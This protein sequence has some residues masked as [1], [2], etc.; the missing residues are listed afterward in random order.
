MRKSLSPV[1]VL[2]RCLLAA[3]LG[4]F[5]VSNQL[6]AQCGL[7]SFPGPGTPYTPTSSF[8]NTQPLGGGTYDEFNVVAG[9]IYSFDF[10]GLTAPVTGNYWD[11]TIST[12]SAIIQYNNSISPIQN[13]WTNGIGCPLTPAPYTSSTEWYAN[14][15]GTVRVNVSTW[16]AINGC[17]LWVSGEGSAVLS[18]KEC[19]TTPDPG[20]G[21]NNWNVD[22]FATTDI[23]LPS[24]IIGARY[25]TYVDNASGTNFITTNYWAQA[26]NP[27]TAPGWTGCQMPNNNFVL[28]ARREGF[29]CGAY[30]VVVNQAVNSIL[31]FLNGTQIY[32]GANINSGVTVG[33]YALTNTDLLEI[34]TNDICNASGGV[35]NVSV[36]PIAP[37]TVHGG[38]IGGVVN[39]ANVCAG[40]PLG[41]FTNITSGSGGTA[42]YTNSAPISYKW[43]LSTNGGASFT[44]VPGVNTDFWN[45]G[46]T[47]PSGATYVVKRI[48][49]DECGNQSPSNTITIFGVPLPNGSISPVSQTICPG[50]T[51]TLTF[52]FNPGTPPFN[53]I[54]TN[55][56]AGGNFPLN[57]LTNGATAQV[58]PSSNANYSFTSITDA[59]GCVTTTGFTQN[60]AVI[61]TPPIVINNIIP[62]PSLCNGSSSGSIV[63]NATGGQ[64]PLS[65][66][67]DGGN[68]FQPGNTFNNLAVGNYN[69]VVKDNLGCSQAGGSVTIGQ[70]SAITMSLTK[71]D[72]SCA[73]VFDG[74]ITVTASGGVPPY[75]YALNGG[76]VQ[77]SN[78]ITGLQTG[79]YVVDVYDSHNCLDTQSIT[80]NPSYVVTLDTLATSDISCNGQG[81]GTI[82]VQ[83]TG[84]IPTYQ[85]SINGFTFQN[86][87]TFTGL[88]SSNYIVIGRDSKGCTASFNVDITQPAP[89]IIAIDSIANVTC[90]NSGNGGIYTSVSGGTPGYTY[91]W[92]NAGVNTP[93]DLNISGG[94]YNVTVTDA[95]NCTATNGATV[96][97]PAAL[98]LNIALHNN[99]F[100]NN[101]SS[102]AILLTA[103]GG[104]APYA[105]AWS[106]GATTQDLDSLGAG[107]YVATVTDINGC[108]NTISQTLTNPT[109]LVASV[110][111]TNVT[112]AGANDGTAGVT[113]SGGNPPYTYLWSNFNVTSSITS[114]S[115]GEYV[116]I[117]SDHSGCQ[118]RDS[119]NVSEPTPIIFTTNVTNISCFN[120]ND[121]SVTTSVTGGTQPYSYAWSNG[122]TT[123]N[124]SSL[125]GGPITGTVTDANHCSASV[126]LNI[127]NPL[128]IAP[129]F[130][131][132]NVTCF[133]D[134]T[135]AIHTTVSGGTPGYT[136]SWTGGATTADLSNLTP[137]TYYVTITDSRSCTTSDSAVVTSPGALYTSGILKNVSC[138]GLCD[139]YIF[140]TPYGGTLPYTYRWSNGYSTENVDLLCGGSY[141]LTLTDA[142][143]CQVASLYIIHEPAQL[144]ETI[145]TTN[146]SCFGNCNGS[147]ASVP[148]GGTTPYQYLWSNF[149]TDSMQSSLCAGKYTL[150]LTDSNGCHLN[151]TV[152]LTQPS[153]IVIAGSV[154]NVACSGFNTGAISLNISG[155]VSPFTFAWSNGATTQNLTGLTAGTDTVVVTDAHGCSETAIFVVA[156]REVIHTT[157]SLY[158]PRCAGGN[159]GFISVVVTGGVI[160]YTYA[161]STTPTQVGA[162]ATNL[163][164]GT[165]ILT[166]TDSVSCS[167]TISA[168]LDNPAPI[169]VT[170][171]N[172]NSRCYNNPNGTVIALASGGFPPYNYTLNGVFQTSDTFT[173]LGPAHYVVLVM[174]ANGCQGTGSFNIS[175]TSPLSVSLSVTDQRILTGMETQLSAVAVSDTTITGYIWTPIAIDSVDVFDYS[176]CGDSANCSTPYVRPPFTTV[177]TVRVMNADSCFATDTVTVYVDNEPGEFRPTAFTPNGDGLNDRFSLTFLGASKIEVTIYNRWGEKVYYN[178]NQ[179]NSLNASDGWDGTDHGKESPLDTYVYQANVTYFNGVVKKITGTVAL[180]R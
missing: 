85:Y 56:L 144:T 62:S 34:R 72:A 153:Q 29:P 52:D 136:Y 24:A 23:S 154:T 112:C 114:L 130:V 102:G 18:Y 61:V 78:V 2:L 66:S 79:T 75:S 64:P 49:V 106:N 39:N 30:N 131:I 40:S 68:T 162:T 76:P 138:H 115:G 86:S 123:S 103:N 117:I 95:N 173:G 169:T 48:T 118:L 104:V 139:G 147:L 122:A 93:N 70:P 19:T 127:I 168:N 11:M 177:F 145:N 84:G 38:T 4:I 7:S 126:S 87:G 172:V 25:G 63:I 90:A 33:Q 1:V 15:T 53:I 141:Y 160:P 16:D 156:Q 101:D 109:A 43:E 128:R 69:I 148:S 27:S 22:V 28:R 107:T 151:D 67:I 51:A 54:Y 100:C 125:S 116:V 165:Y 42:A 20:P 13:S 6:Y 150:L 31:I 92:S 180:I 5:L 59:N 121:G 47:I 88:S 50:G 167:A 161:W 9:N 135:G 46:T 35:A 120:A 83:L 65:Y 133:G 164:A 157:V 119:V 91:L 89:L 137:A 26:S 3:V 58:S 152:D 132:N 166:V 81:N 134:T 163:V 82:V 94:T 140:T 41:N 21:N 12:S 60:A 45:S 174:D 8:Q 149:G 99:P 170:T 32:S 55:L 77:A 155:G 44:Q 111:S 73:G 142:N 159:D 14:Y 158:Q 96:G 175:A 179:T 57:N 124:L 178:P 98:S 74:T 10:T 113:A 176:G 143:G 105:Y 17:Q 80:I 36:T 37:L 129:V 110:V 71:T 171:P 97:S 108:Q 146:V